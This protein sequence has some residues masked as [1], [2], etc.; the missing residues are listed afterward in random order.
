[1]SHLLSTEKSGRTSVTPSVV[2]NPYTVTSPLLSL[3]EAS[4]AAVIAAVLLSLMI[5]MSPLL[6][7]GVTR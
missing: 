5:V 1:M 6:R 3:E 7:P 4:Q 2:L